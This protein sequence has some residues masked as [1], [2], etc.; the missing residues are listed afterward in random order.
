MGSPFR[1][2]IGRGEKK[3]EAILKGFS[4]PREVFQGPRRRLNEKARAGGLKP[5]GE[6]DGHT[7]R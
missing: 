2:T 6:P 7:S 3:F 5:G 4:G 1:G